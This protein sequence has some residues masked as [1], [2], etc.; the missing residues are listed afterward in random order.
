ME[1][2]NNKEQYNDDYKIALVEDQNHYKNKSKNIYNCAQCYLSSTAFA[3]STFGIFLFTMGLFVYGYNVLNLTYESEMV[4]ILVGC[5][6]V[7]I[8]I[9]LWI[10][11]CNYTKSFA[12]L[13][14]L[15]FSI[16]SFT[17]FIIMIGA[18]TYWIIYFE[19]SGSI[20]S[21]DVNNLINATLYDTYKLCCDTNSTNSTPSHVL[22]NVC[23]DILGHNTT[24][25]DI[26][27]SSFNKFEID[28]YSYIQSIFI[29]LL[30][31]GCITLIINLFT[32]ISSCKLIWLYN[33]IYYY[34]S[35]EATV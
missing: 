11:A 25:L 34:T 28:F 12:K 20:N 26:E 32:G 30:V 6:T 16:L 3:M 1:D 4:L 19:S 33:R 24:I 22:N 10:S 2:F 35:P 17:I 23:Y 8:S 27:C 18:I 15:I 31:F 9:L 29:Y 13:I 7:F 5:F 21:T 14:L